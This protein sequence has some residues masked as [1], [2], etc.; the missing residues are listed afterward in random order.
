[1]TAHNERDN[2]PPLVDELRTRLDGE[3][4]ELIVVD[5]GSTDGSDAWLADLG[6]SREDVRIIR[7]PRN[8]GQSTALL[9]GLEAGCGEIVVTLDA[10]GQ[11]DP[12]DL[13]RMLEMLR[14]DDTLAAVV[15]YRE[16]RVDS[17]WKRVQSRVANRVRDVI[18]GDRVRDT[19]CSIRVIRRDFVEG[20][21]RFDGMHRFVPTLIRC[22]GG[23]LVEVPVCHRPRLF[24]TTNYGMWNRV[25]W[26][27]R[28]ALR[29]RKLVAQS[30][31]KRERG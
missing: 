22:Q 11:N 28:D 9:A 25:V 13:P 21:P 31:S 29:V 30:R 17:W 19:G 7:F 16:R 8:R 1:M 5:D 15:G 6:A 14:A 20:L 18:T 24:G 10:D 26:G 4:W 2:L 27:F 12:A 23:R 3:S